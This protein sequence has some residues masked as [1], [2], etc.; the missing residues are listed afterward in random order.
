MSKE[1][2][3]K[4]EKFKDSERDGEDWILVISLVHIQ[5]YKAKVKG[6]QH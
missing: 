5:N 2:E 4:F 6:I 3:I 1:I